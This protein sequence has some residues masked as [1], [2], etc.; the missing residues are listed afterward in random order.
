MIF[1]SALQLPKLY[2]NFALTSFLSKYGAS[3]LFKYLPN[4]TLCKC[5]PHIAM[6]LPFWFGL[7]ENRI[8]FYMP[9]IFARVGD[10]LTKCTDK[11]L[12][13]QIRKL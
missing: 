9:S 11:S 13:L 3:Y 1:N 6:P 8:C 7:Q 12:P 4:L 5:N 10:C 2:F